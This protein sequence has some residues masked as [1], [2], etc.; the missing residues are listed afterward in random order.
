MNDVVINKVA[1][2]QRCLLRIK[3]EFTEEAAFKKSLTQQ[4]SVIL[5]I[6]RACEAA[7]DIA[8]HL[9]KKNNLGI[10][11]SARD[12]FDL[13]SQSGF[14]SATEAENLKK[15]VGLRNIAI[16]DYQKLNLDIVI[17]VV[18]NHLTDFEQF[19]AK[20]IVSA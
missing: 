16:H 11:Q 1:T 14:I 17:A 8:N 10:P 3:E 13:I 12:S 9:I 18:K 6:Q 2:I 19:C 7:I 5:N 15:M 4:D 20:I